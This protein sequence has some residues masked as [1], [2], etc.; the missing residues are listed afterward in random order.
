MRRKVKKKKTPNGAVEEIFTASMERQRNAAERWAD[1]TANSFG[2]LAFFEVNCLIFAAW[3]VWNLGYI[4]MAPIFDPFPFSL[5]TM[6]VSLEAIVL[7]TIVLI[8]Q[9]R[10]ARMAD[11]R[12]EIDLQVNLR[13]ERQITKILQILDKVEHKIHVAHADDKQLAAMEEPFDLKKMERRVSKK[14]R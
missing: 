14:M 1:W 10:A 13:A 7:S 8:S 5:L 9:N 3:I 12:E 2:T 11:I 4:P 6:V